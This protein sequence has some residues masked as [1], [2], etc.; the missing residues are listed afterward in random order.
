MVRV[1]MEIIDE[2]KLDEGAAY[3]M[4]DDQRK[5]LCQVACQYKTE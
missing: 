4:T 1:M 3:R 2:E 5:W